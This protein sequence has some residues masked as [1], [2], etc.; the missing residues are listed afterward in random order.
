[1]DARILS[2]WEARRA[3]ARRLIAH[4][5][6]ENTATATETEDAA[7]GSVAARERNGLG[8]GSYERSERFRPGR[9]RSLVRCTV[10]VASSSR[11]ARTPVV[12]GSE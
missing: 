5:G 6:S 11:L 12:R 7:A 3:A 9:P 4:A 2:T 8:D 10:G 1:M